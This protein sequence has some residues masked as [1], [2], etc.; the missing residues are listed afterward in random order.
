MGESFNLVQALEFPF[1]F[2]EERVIF[3]PRGESLQVKSSEFKVVLILD[4]AAAVTADGTSKGKVERGDLL[5]V[6]VPCTLVYTPLRPGEERLHI[7]RI[8]FKS[9]RGDA[10][11]RQETSME[12]TAAPADA[13]VHSKLILFLQKHFAGVEILQGILARRLEQW[14]RQVRWESENREP[15]YLHRVEAFCR[16]IIVDVARD[17][18]S[19][20]CGAE[21]TKGDTNGATRRTPGKWAVEHVKHYLLQNYYKSLTLDGIANEVKLS[22]EHLSRLFKRE[23]GDTVFKHLK[24][25]RIEA[26]KSMLVSSKLTITEI[27]AKAGFSSA[28]HFSRVFHEVCGQTAKTFRDQAVAGI[29]F[30]RS[31]TQP[32][33]SRH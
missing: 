9:I 7:L 10:Y 25:I 11:Y 29:Q 5:V 24:V 28:M 12:G 20:R 15:G 3:I 4:G 19:A 13:L 14:V 31:A 27:A 17:A 30:E 1:D 18:E 8:A 33:S 22:A 2:V 23:T 16:L 6:P 26:A 32:R 21:R